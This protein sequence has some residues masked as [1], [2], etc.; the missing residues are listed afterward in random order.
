MFRFRDYFKD[1]RTVVIA[2][3]ANAFEGDKA[4]CF[5]M[6]DKAVDSAVDALKF[7]I[8]F[9]DDLLVPEHPKYDVFKR[10]ETKR[11]DWQDILGYAQKT[12]KLIFMDVFGEESFEFSRNFVI[13]AYKIPPSDMANELLIDRVSSSGTSIIL[14]AG[15]SSMK[16][17]ENAINICKKN[18]LKDYVI[19]HGFQSYPTKLEDTNLD[20]IKVLK[21]KFNC[22][23]GYADHGD[24]GTEMAL[25]IPLL[26]VAKGARLIEKHFTLNRDLK[27]TDYQSSV[28]PDVLKKMV[29][30]IKDLD[31][32]FGKSY[33]E[34]SP[35]E[36]EYRRDVRKRVVTRRK[37]K[38]GEKIDIKDLA[39]KRA[40]VGIFA[41]E[42]EKIIGRPV[43]KDFEKN[44]VLE[45]RYVG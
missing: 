12:G 36:E 20:L 6:I 5:E 4:T 7:Q 26:A 17:I 10:L 11:E 35:D 13:D 28:N 37:I 24:G 19:M 1:K 29:H 44:Q 22:P 25:L 38:T 15:A 18:H 32:V 8:F 40:P 16:D 9:A 14:S 21:D 39:F 42:M 30:Y 27:R 23:V 31:I 2:E 3:F 34:L 43:V 33:K 45:W 41:E